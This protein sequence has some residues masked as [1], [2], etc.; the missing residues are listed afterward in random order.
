[1][2]PEHVLIPGGL[3]KD[4]G[5]GNAQRALITFN[6]RRLRN[7]QFG[8][9]KAEVCQQV[10]REEVQHFHGAESREAGGRDNAQRV[11]LFCGS[12]SNTPCPRDL[13]DAWRELV[14]LAG[15]HLLG[16]TCPAQSLRKMRGILRKNDRSHTH[17]TSQ[18]AAS[19]LI[20][21]GNEL[22]SAPDFFFVR[23][24]RV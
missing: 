23:Q 5:C 14:A 18:G 8:Q 7:I 19:R 17:G 22:I 11:D 3:G 13:L 10:V 15:S 16:I 6:Q 1:M 12:K 24:V 21:T 20:Q 2:Q 4:G 9:L